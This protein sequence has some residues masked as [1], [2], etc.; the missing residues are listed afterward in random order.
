MFLRFNTGEQRVVI[1]FDEA[2]RGRGL[3]HAPRRKS[4]TPASIEGQ[5]KTQSVSEA[6][7][8]VSHSR[9]PFGDFVGF[10][11]R[12]NYAPHDSISSQRRG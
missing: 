12:I 9:D 6:E 2:R 3:R 1:A 11:E 7:E 4:G 5:D 10:L 8:G